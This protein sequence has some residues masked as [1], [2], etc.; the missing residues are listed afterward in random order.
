MTRLLA[1]AALLVAA[2]A[3]ARPIADARDQVVRV[4]LDYL[5]IPYLW[6]GEHPGTGMDCSGFVQLVYRRAGLG[7]PRVARD[8]FLA[9]SKLAP[10]SVLPGDLVF[11]SM[12]R[13]GSSRVDHVGIYVGRGHF[14]HAS[15]TNG[16][17]IEAI[18]NPYYLSR[19]VAI[20]KYR[21]F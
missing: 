16:I 4:T 18:T 15:V 14:I 13:P 7:L 21:G 1:L 6:G 8:Q 3:S 2:P 5:N 20:R 9:T 10:T 11:F 17:H 12:K 19:L